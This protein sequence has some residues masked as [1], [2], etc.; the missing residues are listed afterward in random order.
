LAVDVQSGDWS[1]VL[2]TT[3]P[4][5]QAA[6][7]SG[8]CSAFTVSEQANAALLDS[9]LYV[10][11]RSAAPHPRY[12]STLRDNAATLA[13]IASYTLPTQHFTTF[14]S[15]TAPQFRLN[16]YF[17]LPPTFHGTLSDPDCSFRYPV[18]V[19]VYGGPGNQQVSSRYA[20]GGN[21]GEGF[22]TFLSGSK[23]YVTLTVDPIGT[24]GKGDT[25]RKNYTTG[26]LWQQE[27]VDVKDV[28]DSLQSLCFVDADRVAYWVT[29]ST[30]TTPQAHSAR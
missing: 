3:S 19:H 6:S 18:L 2:N 23:G 30:H 7:F 26:R 10:V 22:G 25:F 15:K 20:R 11:D 16:A 13:L 17:L 29:R 5:W 1:V 4:T 9:R 28:I 24:G 21:A 8:N 14:P 12:V 27:E